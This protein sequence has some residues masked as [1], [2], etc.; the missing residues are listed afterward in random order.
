MGA[1][2]K[3]PWTHFLMV[4]NTTV[5]LGKYTRLKTPARGIWQSLPI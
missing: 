1:P 5:A 3:T 2:V 4:V